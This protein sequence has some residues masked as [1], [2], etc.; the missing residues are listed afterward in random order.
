MVFTKVIIIIIW[1]KTITSGKKYS[2]K[3]RI[4]MNIFNDFFMIRCYN[5]T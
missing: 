2:L 5:I 1:L 3:E 4:I